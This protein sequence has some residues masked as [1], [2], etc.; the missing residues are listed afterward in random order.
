MPC[1][2]PSVLLTEHVRTSSALSC[3]DSHI[4]CSS[5]LVSCTCE[6]EKLVGDGGLCDSESDESSVS[7]GSSGGSTSGVQKELG[8]E[9]QVEEEKVVK[10]RG[11]R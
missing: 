6:S 9:V 8:M 11:R 2:D 5:S 4:A 10:E 3:T 1:V 7:I